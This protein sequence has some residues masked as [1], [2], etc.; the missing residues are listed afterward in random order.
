MDNNG[1]GKGCSWDG[2]GAREANIP[3]GR[4]KGRKN[5]QKV[6]TLN[7]KNYFFNKF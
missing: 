7:K 2:G 3:G 4:V 5:G 6:N 1:G